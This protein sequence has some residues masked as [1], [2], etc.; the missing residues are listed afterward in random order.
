MKKDGSKS[1]MVR[2]RDPKNRSNQGITVASETEAETLKRL[3]DA[4]GQSFEVAQHSGPAI[5]PVRITKSGSSFQPEG[6]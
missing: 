2:W 6:S 4:N 1:Y 5:G 3:L